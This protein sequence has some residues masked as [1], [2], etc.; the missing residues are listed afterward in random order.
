MPRP[1]LQ[2]IVATSGSTPAVFPRGISINVAAQLTSLTNSA[3]ALMS[4]T[5]LLHV[6]PLKK[7]GLSC[8]MYTALDRNSPHIRTCLQADSL[9]SLAASANACKDARTPFTWQA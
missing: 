8:K 4:P 3:P 2:S 5:Q 6:A 1:L 9:L 7:S